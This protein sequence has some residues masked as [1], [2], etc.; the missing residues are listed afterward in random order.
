MDM[1]PDPCTFYSSNDVHFTSHGRVHKGTEGR[2]IPNM[3][4]K[5][6]ELGCMAQRKFRAN[7][8]L[9]KG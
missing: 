5:L 8:G 7:I 6:V 4:S 9:P 2:E 3:G 1:M